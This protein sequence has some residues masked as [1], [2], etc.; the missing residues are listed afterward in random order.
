MH[1]VGITFNQDTWEVEGLGISRL[2][3]VSAVYTRG[4][5]TL[6]D[7]GRIDAGLDR[8]DISGPVS[9]SASPMKASG[10]WLVCRPTAAA[11]EEP[12]ARRIMQRLARR[13][14]RRPVTDADVA[15]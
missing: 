14:Y 2:P 4:R 10:N 15:P 6:P 9:Q 8:L 1:T 12:C 13:A 3:L 7:V 11:E 5:L